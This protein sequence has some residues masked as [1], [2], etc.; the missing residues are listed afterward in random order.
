MSSH[1]SHHYPAAGELPLWLLAGFVF[2]ALSVLIFHQGA[3][4]LLH[5]F[6]LTPSAPYSMAP[7]RPWG[8]PQIASIAL[9]GGLWGIALTAALGRLQGARL[10]LAA[11]VF[12]ALLPS[13]VAWFV[14]APLK[15][16]PMAAGGVPA[17]LLIGLIVNGAWGLGTG[18][19]LA[20]LA[21]RKTG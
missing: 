14:V 20:L 18:I 6:G 5:A 16:Q 10:I 8:I 12:G 4:S 1:A 7:T 21:R 17:R 13:L 11:A 19:G 9:W 2:G 3:L 15:G